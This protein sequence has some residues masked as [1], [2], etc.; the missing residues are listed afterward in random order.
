MRLTMHYFPGRHRL[1]LCARKITTF[2]NRGLWKM[3]AA[4]TGGMF[5]GRCSVIHSVIHVGYDDSPDLSGQN[6]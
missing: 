2:T 4:G 1:S 3:A 6:P 5:W